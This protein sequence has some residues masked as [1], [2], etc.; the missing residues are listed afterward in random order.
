MSA[1]M[2]DAATAGVTQE[3]VVVFSLAGEH[4]ALDISRLQGIIKLPEVTRIP[5]APM[6]V[7]GVINLR[8]A[9]VPVL[10]LR[11]RFGLPERTD[12]PDTRIIN[13][14][15]GNN[16][17]GLIVD[18]VDQVINIPSGVIEPTPDLVTTVD[19][20]YLRAIAKLEDR[21]VTLLDLDRVLTREEE[22]SLGT[23]SLEESEEA[24]EPIPG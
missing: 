19:S 5:R 17:V 23:M 15:M 16:L 14:E 7:E 10:D 21:L 24:V 20:T 12:T 8:G 6:F 18:S 3:Q 13:V 11:R 4:Y 22:Q 2:I 1:V 9:I